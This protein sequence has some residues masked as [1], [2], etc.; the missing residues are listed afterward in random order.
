M[1]NGRAVILL[2][3]DNRADQILI[4]EALKNSRRADPPHIVQDGEEAISYLSRT[5]RYA[6]APRPD[7]VLLDLN[8]PKRNGREVLV[9]IKQDPALRQIPVLVL[10]SSQEAEEIYRSYDAGANCY[11]TKRADLDEYFTILRGVEE[12]WLTLANLPPHGSVDVDAET[13]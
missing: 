8:L 7:L 13:R 10:T 12:F 2:V 4:Q 11:L 6:D 1:R 9:F 3:E 5:G